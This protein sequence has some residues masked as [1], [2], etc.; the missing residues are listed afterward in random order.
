MGSDFENC[1]D[2]HFFKYYFETQVDRNGCEMK[3]FKNYLI[4]C[5][6]FFLSK[7]I[8]IKSEEINVFLEI[9]GD[10][11][12][13]NLNLKVIG[14]ETIYVQNHNEIESNVLFNDLK[15]EDHADRVTGANNK[16]HYQ[17]NLNEE[18]VIRKIV[19]LIPDCETIY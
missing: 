15:A 11:K 1:Y 17:N 2:Y 18:K 10:F 6:I 12:H 3:M 13:S 4:F 19:F 9:N 14:K 16:N 7:N 8:S 5:V